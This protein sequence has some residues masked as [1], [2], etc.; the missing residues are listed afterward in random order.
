MEIVV[1]NE[2]LDRVAFNVGDIIV[3]C[4]ESYLVSQRPQYCLVSLKGNALACGTH[5]T[6]LDLEDKVNDICKNLKDIRVFSKD[7][8]KLHIERRY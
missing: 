5:K 8:Y 3:W 4:G 7:D 1:N 2:R 6:L